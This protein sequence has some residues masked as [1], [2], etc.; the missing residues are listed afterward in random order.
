VDTI[1]GEPIHLLNAVVHRV[2]SPKEGN[3][4]KEPVNGVKSQIGE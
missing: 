1:A 2:T 3:G 4:V